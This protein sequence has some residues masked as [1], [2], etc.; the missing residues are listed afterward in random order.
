MATSGGTDEATNHSR[1]KGGGVYVYT[2][3]YGGE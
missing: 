1:R 3:T 2:Q